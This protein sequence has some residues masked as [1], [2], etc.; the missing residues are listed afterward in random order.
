MTIISRRFVMVALAFSICSCAPREIVLGFIGGLSGQGSEQAVEARNGARIAVEDANAAGGVA[1]FHIR[2]LP[3]DDLKTPEGAVAAFERLKASGAKA[4]VGPMW[5]SMSLAVLP[6]ANEASIPL[7]SPTASSKDLT[8]IDDMFLRVNPPDVS[9][10]RDLARFV[11][12]AGHTMVVAAYDVRNNRS[13]AEGLARDFPQVSYQAVAKEGGTGDY[14]SGDD[15]SRLAVAKRILTRFPGRRSHHRGGRR[16][17]LPRPAAQAQ[18][19]PWH[20]CTGLV[21]H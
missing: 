6:L 17:G 18:R 9:E 7:V 13:F 3:E 5:S 2:F 19:A 11:T 14:S 15:P 12:A 4:I 1:G 16:Y 10:S 21:G 8:G 20:P